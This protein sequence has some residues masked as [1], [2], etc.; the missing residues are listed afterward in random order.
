MTTH[1]FFGYTKNCRRV[2]KEL[3]IP[4]PTIIASPVSVMALTGPIIE[5]ICLPWEGSEILNAARCMTADFNDVTTVYHI[6]AQPERIRSAS[7]ITSRQSN[8]R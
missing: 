6:L 7:S 2:A 8:A 3:G 5:H 4:D 1:I